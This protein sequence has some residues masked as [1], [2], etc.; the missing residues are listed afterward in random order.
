M[1]ALWV[2]INSASIFVVLFQWCAA[3]ICSQMSATVDWY[4]MTLADD[5]VYMIYSLIALLVITLHVG[6]VLDSF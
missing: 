4:R 5:T 1:A 6:T 2:G 3:E